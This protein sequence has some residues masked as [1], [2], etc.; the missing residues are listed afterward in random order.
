MEE[1]PIADYDGEGGIVLRDAFL[2]KLQKRRNGKDRYMVYESKEGEIRVAT[3]NTKDKTIDVLD[4][5]LGR[6]VNSPNGL[7]LGKAKKGK[8]LTEQQNKEAQ[9]ED[10]DVPDIASVASSSNT[11]QRKTRND[12]RNDPTPCGGKAVS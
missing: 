1:E 2:G 11:T 8:K 7:V 10:D 5:F 4:E 9:E 12:D 3:Y 6:L